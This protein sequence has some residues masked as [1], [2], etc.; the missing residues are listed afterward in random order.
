MNLSDWL[1]AERGRL[2]ALAAHFDVTQ[3]AVTQWRTTGVPV[4]RMRAVVE[5][6]DGAVTYE[7][8]VSQREERHRATPA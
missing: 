6:T 1:D 4:T 2:T 8:M 3:A 7:D 5:F